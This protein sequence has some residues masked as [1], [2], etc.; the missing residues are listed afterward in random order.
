MISY[1]VC[2]GYIDRRA[3]TEKDTNLKVGSVNLY[4]IISTIYFNN[5]YFEMFNLCYIN[6]II[7][8]Y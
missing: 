6:I 8:Y 3:I 2:D 7:G 5:N 4:Y 1:F